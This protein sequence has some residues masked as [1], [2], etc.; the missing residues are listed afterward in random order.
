MITLIT[1]CYNIDKNKLEVVGVKLLIEIKEVCRQDYKKAQKFAI[2]GMHLDWYMDSKVILDLYAKY[3][4]YM[5]LNR[6]T[7][8]YGAYIDDIF[9]GVLLAEIKNEPKRYY[10]V[11]K[12]FYVK[13]FDW[14][15]HLVAGKGVEEYDEANKDMYKSFCQKNNPDGEIIFLPLTL[16]A[17]LKV[18]EQHYCLHLKKMKAE[19][20]FIYTQIMLA[21]INFMSIEVLNVQKNDKLCLT[22]IKGK[23]L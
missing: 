20:L 8:V 14:L 15:Q 17:K 3:F 13:I 18:L 10:S 21:L 11:S 23:S 2:Q 19:N 5:E 6:A 4:W 7:K 1:A 22:W 16:I 9:V 12:A